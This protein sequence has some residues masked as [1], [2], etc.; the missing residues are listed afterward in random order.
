MMH[1]TEIAAQTFR[2]LPIL[3]A[4]MQT[5]FPVKHARK[6]KPNGSAAHKSDIR[7]NHHGGFRNTV[8]LPI[9]IVA[10]QNPTQ[11]SKAHSLS[12]LR[13]LV[14]VTRDLIKGKKSRFGEPIDNCEGEGDCAELAG[15][16]PV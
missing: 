10:I 12:T 3:N 4:V 8:R 14:W 16:I 1:M 15:Y 7:S 9:P 13:G 6:L 11:D 2:K 5:V